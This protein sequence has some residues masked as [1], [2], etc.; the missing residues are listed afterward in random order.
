VNEKEPFFAP[1]RF[2]VRPAA[3]AGAP[4]V[5]DRMERLVV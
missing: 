5:L 2:E 1:H 3:F 4:F